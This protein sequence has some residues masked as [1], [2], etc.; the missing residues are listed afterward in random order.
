MSTVSLT[1]DLDI[2]PDPKLDRRKRR[3]RTVSTSF[4]QPGLE[5]RKLLLAGDERKTMSYADKMYNYL[6][7]EEAATEEEE[8]EEEE[9]EEGMG[10]RCLKK[11][12]GAGI[13]LVFLAVCIFQGSNVLTKKM[14]VHPLMTVLLADLLKF[15]YI[16]PFTVHG[17]DNPFP[18]GRTMLILARGFCAGLQL[19]GHYY[20]IKHLPI[21]DITMISSIKPVC[22]TLLACIFLRESCG[23]FEVLNLVLVVT[24]IGLVVQPSFI[25]GQTDSQYDQQM[26]YAAVGLC[27]AQVLGSSVAV[28]LRHLRDIHWAALGI[29]TRIFSVIEISVAL[30]VMG[31]FCLPSC[32]ADRWRIVAVA[33]LGN[34]TQFCHIVALKVEQAHIVS[35]TDNAS[36]IFVSF[37]FQL[38][39]FQDS[40]NL[41]KILGACVVIFSILLM[42]GSKI[43][44]HKKTEK[45][46]KKLST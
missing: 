22:S 6:L 10:L 14:T 12:P 13:L 34:I 16:A 40:P 38:I 7:S 19:V 37:L 2:I 9:E 33:V 39:F 18:R 8:G 24:G 17:G 3:R 35:V 43:Y 41:L 32:G 15:T 36:G 45:F 27:V 29:S 42:G 28:I 1:P 5:N 20:A 26:F 30:G 4:E 44:K 46:G 25:F 31:L 11:V 23:L 21:S